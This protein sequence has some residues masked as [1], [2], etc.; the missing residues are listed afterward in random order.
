MQHAWKQM[1][2]DGNGAVSLVE[3]TAFLSSTAL[4]NINVTS[5]HGDTAE[6]A[7]LRPRGSA[8][9]VTSRGL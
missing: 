5:R 4:A 3:F 2:S 1:D 9:R 8:A 7:P 6:V